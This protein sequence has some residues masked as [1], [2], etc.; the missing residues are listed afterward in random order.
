MKRHHVMV[1]DDDHYSLE[2]YNFTV[3]WSGQNEF[4]RSE[5]DP[6]KALEDL[7]YC[8]LSE[9]EKFPEY[10]L[11]DLKM[12]QMDGFT[13]IEEFEKFFPDQL[14]RISFIITT[15]SIRKQDKI[16][17]LSYE[18]VKDFISKPI[19]ADYIERLIKEGSHYPLSKHEN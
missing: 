1:I 17:A 8:S 19:P 2:L 10:I 14:D 5:A 7:K 15:S 13:F 16:K 4:Y 18:N 12:P 9:P 3:K 6:L 11:L